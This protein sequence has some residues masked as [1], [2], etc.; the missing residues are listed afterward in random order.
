MKNLRIK[1][2]GVSKIE[3]I[4][5]RVDFV[6]SYTDSDGLRSYLRWQL[7]EGERTAI[8]SLNPSRSFIGGYLSLLLG[9]SDK[10]KF[11]PPETIEEAL[12]LF[13]EHKKYRIQKF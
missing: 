10:V 1:E 6:F 11:E 4:S 2:G 5:P 7:E 8:Q 9:L 13:K 3:R 12:R